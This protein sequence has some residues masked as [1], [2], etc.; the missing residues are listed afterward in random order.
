M[1]R[2]KLSA[3]LVLNR[4]HAVRENRCWQWQWAHVGYTLCFNCSFLIERSKCISRFTKKCILG[5]SLHVWGWWFFPFD[6]ERAKSHSR[7]WK[8]WNF[9]IGLKHFPCCPETSCETLISSKSVSS[10]P[11]GGAWLLDVSPGWSETIS[12]SQPYTP[13]NLFASGKNSVRF[14]DSDW[15]NSRWKNFS[16]DVLLPVNRLFSQS[17]ENSFSSSFLHRM[18]SQL[19]LF[20]LIR[21]SSFVTLLVCV[22]NCVCARAQSLV[23]TKKHK[24]RKKLFS[25]FTFAWTKKSVKNST[26]SRKHV[27]YPIYST[28]F[29]QQSE[30]LK[31]SARRLNMAATNVSTG[32]T[33]SYPM[34]SLYVGK[35]DDA[36]GVF[37]QSLY[38]FSQVTF[39]LMSPRLCCSTSSQAPVR[40]SRFESVVIWSPD[41]RSV[42]LTWTFNNQ[43]TVSDDWKPFLECR[44]VFRF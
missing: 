30:N 14:T 3:E 38:F 25:N 11:C 20:T 37:W 39:I 24:K 1:V 26:K 31:N 13:S 42:M 36:S 19:Y 16:T 40:F 32:A 28:T 44:D 10:Q 35:F 27:N 5:R 12:Q 23:G 8:T 29:N 9:I 7:G 18:R 41:D 33:S 6:T 2:S 15:R 22:C 34:A 4:L 43:R 21:F 17:K